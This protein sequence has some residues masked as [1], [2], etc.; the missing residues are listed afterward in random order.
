MQLKELANPR[1]PFPSPDSFRP[2][3]FTLGILLCLFA[4]TFWFR[5]RPQPKPKQKKRSPQKEA[6]RKCAKL[7]KRA[8]EALPP[9]AYRCLASDLSSLVRCYYQGQLRQPCLGLSQRKFLQILRLHSTHQAKVL[10]PFLSRWEAVVYAKRPWEIW[11]RRKD[12]QALR[13]FFS[14]IEEIEA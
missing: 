5:N 11:E 2:I 12:I 13:S 6:L 4:L 10:A 8:K 9:Q 1:G 3:G 14:E 7:E